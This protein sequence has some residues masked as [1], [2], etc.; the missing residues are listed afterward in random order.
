[1]KKKYLFLVLF[2]VLGISC[3]SQTKAKAKKNSAS[4]KITVAQHPA[5]I[6][7]ATPVLTKTSLPPNQKNGP[8]VYYIVNDNPVDHET[9]QRSQQ[10]SRK[11]N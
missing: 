3:F 7:A 8:A 4:E 9:Y 2:L 10:K 1:M 5:E 11:T 6:T